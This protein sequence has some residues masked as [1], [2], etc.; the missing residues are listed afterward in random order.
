MERGR[1][2]S[3]AFWHG[4]AKVVLTNLP[5]TVWVSHHGYLV[6]ACPEHLRPATDDEKFIL[7]DYIADIM[8]SKHDIE[9]NN[10]RGFVIL[11]ELPPEEP[12]LPQG[13]V[14]KFRLTGKTRHEDVDF[15]DPEPKRMR[16]E[17]QNE[18]KIIQDDQASNA[19]SPTE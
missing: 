12:E 4:P 3:P 6:K 15:K 14:P 17:D 1:K 2:D 8:D 7:T 13:E 16:L 10:V 9:K 18:E 19:Y 11:D 5:S